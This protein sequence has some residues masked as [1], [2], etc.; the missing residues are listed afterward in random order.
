MELLN[1]K[2]TARLLRCTTRT[3]EAWRKQANGPRAI[4][5]GYRWFYRRRD[6]EDFIDQAVAEADRENVEIRRVKEET[7]CAINSP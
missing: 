7:Q 3:L 1:T 6:V 5:I 2:E 4:L